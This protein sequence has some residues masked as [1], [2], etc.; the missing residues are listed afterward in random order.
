MPRR[1]T[2]FVLLAL[3]MLPCLAHGGATGK[4]AGRILDQATGLPL[5]FVTVSVPEI[6][7][8]AETDMS[9]YYHV[10]NV[11]PGIYTV[12]TR[13]LGYANSEVKGVRVVQDQTAT[14]NFN[15]SGKAIEVEEVKVFADKIIPHDVTESR[16]VVTGKS[17]DIMPVET[18]QEALL[19]QTS[20]VTDPGLGE[21]HIRGGRGGE[22]LYL[23][24]GMSIRDPLVGGGFGMRVGRNALEEMAVITGG[25]NAEYGNAQSG[26]INLVTREGADR[27]T[28]RIYYKTDDL[29]VPSLNKYSFNTDISEFSLGGKE[30]ITQYLLPALG[31]HLP[32][33]VSYFASGTGEW[34]DTYTPF[35]VRRSI[36]KMAGIQ[37][38]DRQQ[39][40]YTL[41]SKF[42]WNLA[43][44]KN[45]KK[46]TLGLRG[47]TA[48]R[49]GYD[50]T[51]RYIPQ[52]CYKVKEE[53]YQ[54]NLSWNHTLTGNTFY[55]ASLSKF[56]TG[57]EVRPGGH[58]PN[59]IVQYTG[60][61]HGTSTDTLDINMGYP[62]LDGQDEPYADRDIYNGLYDFGES[63]VD[64]NASGF[65][66][67]G[68]PFTD[69][70]AK[71]GHYDLGEPFR[72][73]NGNGQWDGDEPFYDYGA[74]G[75]P[76]THDV[77]ESDGFYQLGEPFL[78]YN[79][80]GVRDEKVA[81]GFYDW[82]Y[83]Q[84]TQWHK[85]RT[86]IYTLK[87]DV[88]SQRG[89]NHLLKGGFEMNY[90][91]IS[92]Q[93]IQYGW[94]QDPERPPVSGPW[95]NIGI[96]RD[97]YF[98]TPLTGAA[99]LQDKIETEGMV[100]NAGFR[101]DF[102][103]PGGQVDALREAR[104][105]RIL[106]VKLGETKIEGKVSP[107]LGIAYPITEKDL[108]YFSYGHFSQ[109][110]ELQYL[111]EDTTQFGAAIRLYGNPNL[112]AERTVSYELGVKHAFS[113]LLVLDLTGFFKDVRGLVDTEKRGVPPLTYQ[114]RVN[115]DY[116]NTRGIE[117]AFDRKYSHYIAGTASYTLAWAM[118]KS[119]SDRQGYDY[120]NSG[121]PLPLREY[122]LNWDQRHS[123]AVNADVRAFKGE[124]PS[125]FGIVKLPD[126][127]GVYV[128]WQYGSGLPFTGTDSLQ[129]QT[130]NDRRMPWTSTV[131]MK[132][133]KDFGV[134]PLSYSFIL[135]IKNMFDKKN[136]QSVHSDTGTP[137]GDGRPIEMNPTNWGPGRNI[138][139]GLSIDW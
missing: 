136:V 14:V 16:Q 2:A 115:K 49:D 129:S 64:L 76:Y 59:E 137:E 100:I 51:F 42:T 95:P 94:W 40:I 50:W 65:W 79:K 111:Y 66:D 39:N 120:D 109:I 73:W 96:F 97:N 133:N 60:D 81:D 91:E 103:G 86:T 134:G 5:P 128:L 89:Q 84:W 36:Y 105:I 4:I 118:G 19:T 123:V 43:E 104:P 10:L 108:L 83:D 11:P 82:G 88:T 44:Q 23:V 30:P 26:V 74:D 15:L 35:N 78:D 116:G 52:D 117:V 20:V 121:T 87:T 38:G 17:L 21:I 131:D 53:S 70:A 85:R 61:T 13:L 72:D 93:E 126:R 71:N 69:L 12:Q 31:V 37:I 18:P 127:W 32:G 75:E 55:N 68:E 107:R 9:G 101:V 8:V 41:N 119:S 47:S 113:E 98:R 48:A 45:Q 46:L 138:R 3:L 54:V 102:W 110:P 34:T 122:P 139:V 62:G 63:F 114:L 25:F 106:G 1:S 57:R 22:I 130:P 7:T 99:Y 24:D 33:K 56:V 29:M 92:Q 112:S 27:M 77:G 80:N 132:A 67:W 58:L 135:E 124:H 6:M 90:H 28:G 125:P